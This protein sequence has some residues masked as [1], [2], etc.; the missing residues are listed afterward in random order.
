MECQGL[1]SDLTGCFPLGDRTDSLLNICLLHLH[2]IIHKTKNRAI[3][4]IS[5][6]LLLFTIR[7]FIK[8]I[9]VNS[10]GIKNIVCVLK[11][12]LFSKV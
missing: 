3:Y 4:Y 2:I 11:D 7:K 9:R 8:N 6:S 5:D 12:S 1:F 10:V